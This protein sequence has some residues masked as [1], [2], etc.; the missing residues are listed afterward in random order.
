MDY[1]KIPNIV[2]DK[3]YSKVINKDKIINFLKSESNITKIENY[4]KHNALILK[5]Y[6]TLKIK[7]VIDIMEYSNYRINQLKGLDKVNEVFETVKK[8]TPNLSNIEVIYTPYFINDKNKEGFRHDTTYIKI[9]DELYEVRNVDRILSFLGN[10]EIIRELSE[11]E[12]TK[13]IKEHSNLIKTNYLDYQK[14]EITSEQ[15]EEEIKRESDENIRK[16]LMTH[17]DDVVKEREKLEEYINKNASGSI[18]TYGVNSNEERIYTVKDKLIKFEGLDRKLQILTSREIENMTMGNFE[19]KDGYQ[20]ESDKDEYSNI[21]DFINLEDNLSKIVENLFNGENLTNEEIVMLTN[22]IKLY[23]ENK[24]QGNEITPELESIGEKWYENTS[25]D[26]N[27]PTEE[28][29]ELYERI[30][31]YRKGKVKTYELDNAAFISVFA[32]LETSL[33]IGLII[34]LI[35]LFK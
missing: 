32:I 30:R 3:Y 6:P 19:N 34:S 4:V 35:L 21:N 22:F 26:K 9:K 33:V 2:P 29:S 5:N 15:V 27:F 10:K 13:F 17:K 1:R 20:K 31:I 28:L 23:I 25:I 11:Y 24:E 18:V 14:N 16:A 7:D 12:I 8:E